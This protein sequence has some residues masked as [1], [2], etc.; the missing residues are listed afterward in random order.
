MWTY[1]NACTLLIWW[2]ISS[3][4]YWTTALITGRIVRHTS[5]ARTHF[6]HSIKVCNQF[7][8][9]PQWSAAMRLCYEHH[10]A[11][12]TYLLNHFEPLDIID[13][14]WLVQ[15]FSFP[16]QAIQPNIHSKR[17]QRVRSKHIF[18][19]KAGLQT[20]LL[21]WRGRWC[22]VD[23]PGPARC[24]SVLVTQFRRACRSGLLTVIP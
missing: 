22:N 18:T 17:L 13:R 7:D 16:K 2:P 11:S 23:S 21:Y 14:Y 6:M 5:D 12:V 9:E 3:R 19:P 1:W 15:S 8:T 10:A 20:T 24:W 4:Y